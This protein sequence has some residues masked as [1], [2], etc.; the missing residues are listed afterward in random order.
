VKDREKTLQ[1]ALVAGFRG[2]WAAAMRTIADELDSGAQRA[3]L[4]A[5]GKPVSLSAP[6][7]VRMLLARATQPPTPQVVRMDPG[8]SLEQTNARVDAAGG[9]PPQSAP[10]PLAAVGPFPTAQE[11]LPVIAGLLAVI[12][13]NL[14]THQRQAHAEWVALAAFALHA[15]ECAR[16]DGVLE[17]L[18]REAEVLHA[19][20]LAP[21]PA[22]Q[23]GATA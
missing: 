10:P 7:L 4:A 14:A 6:P 17:Q 11:A 1:Q 21:T 15:R 18:D 3:K 16:M 5:G 19:L 20:V 2:G 13:G 8:E 9:P 23:E 12:A 22:G